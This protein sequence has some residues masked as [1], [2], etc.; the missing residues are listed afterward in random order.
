MIRPSSAL[1]LDEM[2]TNTLF[3][4]RISRDVV[5]ASMYDVIRP[6]EVVSEVGRTMSSTS[7]LLGL[8]L[9]IFSTSLALGGSANGFLLELSRNDFSVLFWSL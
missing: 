9:S 2:K 4:T 3:L 1:L 8:D 7:W 5:R 6:I